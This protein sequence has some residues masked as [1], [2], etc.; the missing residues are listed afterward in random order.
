MVLTCKG[1][2]FFDNAW[3]WGNIS[4]CVIQS[5][6]NQSRPWSFFLKVISYGW[7]FLSAIFY[8]NINFCYRCVC[9]KIFSY[10][11]ARKWRLELH[12]LNVFN[13]TRHASTNFDKRKK[14]IVLNKN[15]VQ[16]LLTFMKIRDFVSLL[17]ITVKTYA[18]NPISYTFLS[19]QN[20]YRLL[21][22]FQLA[23]RRQCLLN[24]SQESG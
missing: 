6:S 7:V 4:H 23:I 13:K 2:T 15:S 12:H 20:Y 19:A 9:A 10:I 11:E 16:I 1:N 14:I 22:L 24:W 21:T 8:G 3:F 17:S 18:R 5:V